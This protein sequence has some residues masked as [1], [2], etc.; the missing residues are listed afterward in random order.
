VGQTSGSTPGT[1]FDTTIANVARVYDYM[2]GGKNNFAADRELGDQLQGAFPQSAWIARQN[3]AFVRRAVQH[4]AEDGVRQFLDIGSGLPTMDNVHEVARRFCPGAGVVYVDNDR[5]AVAHA[6]ALLATSDGVAALQGD[7]RDPGAIL[8]QVCERGLLDLSQPLVV[9]MTAVLHFIP[10]SADP[11]R[12]VAAFR[13]A[14]PPGSYLVLSHASHDA[15]P[16]GT[17]QAREMYRSAS[18]SS[19]LVT[20]TL[21]EVVALFGGLDLVEPGVVLTTH[22][23]P[24]EPVRVSDPGDL[25][26]GAARKP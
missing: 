20:R 13:D 25:Y 14:M 10:D 26:A 11:A 22:W 23:R 15:R 24:T 8:A 6:S 4:C 5:V 19:L 3:R 18:A 12:L 21:D 17:A 9:L 1:A 2:L 7:L 16:E